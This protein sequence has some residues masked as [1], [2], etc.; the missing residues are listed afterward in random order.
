[1]AD[2]RV[3]RCEQ[4]LRR[5]PTQENREALDSTLT[6]VILEKQTE[7]GEEFD[8]IHSVERALSVGSLEKINAPQE[9]RGSLIA[10]L[11]E[12]L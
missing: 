5:H 6:D 9:M 2:P 8:S 3:V 7:L 4:A 10:A 11:R 12:M 1:L